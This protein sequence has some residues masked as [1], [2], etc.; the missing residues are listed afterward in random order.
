MEITQLPAC[1]WS[2]SFSLSLNDNLLLLFDILL[3]Y[4]FSKIDLFI[5]ER[6][7]EREK[8]RHRQREK[9]APCRELNAGLDSGPGNQALSQRQMLNR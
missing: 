2:Q 4:L 8:Q 7:K 5:H 6:H 9:Q 1:L 3:I